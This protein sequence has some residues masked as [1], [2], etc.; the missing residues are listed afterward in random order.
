MV[1]PK[2]RKN[3]INPSTSQQAKASPATMGMSRKRKALEKKEETP[4]RRSARKRSK[5]TEE[6]LVNEPNITQ[7]FGKKEEEDENIQQE[8]ENIQQEAELEPKTSQ[9][10]GKWTE[11]MEQDT[12]EECPN[13]KTEQ[14][15]DKPVNA[16]VIIIGDD[17]S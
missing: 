11:I 15:H 6:I 7:D 2:D 17:S 9:Q 14:V 3:K 4:L 8:D 1:S 10:E 13:V 16:K 5:T 12:F